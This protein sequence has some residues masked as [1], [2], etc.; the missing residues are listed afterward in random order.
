MGALP[1]S[2]KER[3]REG[4]TKTIQ[5]SIAAVLRIFSPQEGV[6]PG[7]AQ[8]GCLWRLPSYYANHSATPAGINKTHI[9][10]I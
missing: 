9:H 4:K 5:L 10:S 8:D 1:V 6:E 3:C 7:L 2:K